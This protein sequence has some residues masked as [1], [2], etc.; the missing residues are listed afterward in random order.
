LAAT[1]SSVG[2]FSPTGQWRVPLVELVTLLMASPD[3]MTST[4]AA[5]V[6][7]EMEAANMRQE[8]AEQTA[9]YVTIVEDENWYGND[10]HKWLVE[11]R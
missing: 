7:V 9:L 3:T 2:G 5:R 11:D 1:S 4:R 6:L 10:S 8:R